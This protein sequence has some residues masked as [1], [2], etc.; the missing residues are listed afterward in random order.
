ME[1]VTLKQPVRLKVKQRV[2]KT[3][4]S[5]NGVALE[6]IV[7]SYTLRH[8]AGSIPVL[9]LNILVPKVELDL[10]ECEVEEHEINSSF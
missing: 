6:G 10:E 1:E 8:S 5:V 7:S 3:E 2:D 9:S 4:L